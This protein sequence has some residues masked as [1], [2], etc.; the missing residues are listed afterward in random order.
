M[1]SLEQC[2]D[3]LPTHQQKAAS[4]VPQDIVNEDQLSIIQFLAPVC[5]FWR[6]PFN[7]EKLLRDLED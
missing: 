6:V 4:K 1:C 7:S 5:Q 2:N 3:I